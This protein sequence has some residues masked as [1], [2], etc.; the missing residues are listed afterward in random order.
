MLCFR[1]IT[2]VMTDYAINRCSPKNGT[3]GT[4]KMLLRQDV[5]VVFGPVC[6]R[7]ILFS[8]QAALR[9]SEGLK[10]CC[11]FLPDS[12]TAKRPPIK[13]YTT[14]LLVECTQSFHLAF[15]PNHPLNFTGG[16]RQT[17]NVQNVASIFHHYR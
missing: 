14:C 5:D 2:H 8:F 9:M 15:A 13:M 11:I 16:E 1:S 17:Q 6:S 3:F 10:R 7:G 12:H 4:L